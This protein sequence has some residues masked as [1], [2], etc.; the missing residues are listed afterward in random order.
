MN[1]QLNK[2]LIGLTGEYLV[3]G[4]MSMKGWVASLTLKNYPAVD[5][6]GLNPKTEQTINIQ[7]KTI[8]NGKNYPVGSGFNHDN[9]EKEVCKRI[10]S[11]Y[12]FVHIDKN[13]QV[14]YFI[15]SAKILINLLVQSNKDYLNKSRIK[16]VKGTNPIGLPLNYILP[17]EDLWINLW[18]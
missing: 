16:P 2:H 17:Y 11:P 18:K 10:K 9:L 14:R 12:V 1:N 5:I 7:V 3:A 13:D 8:R 4:M 15:V 6:F